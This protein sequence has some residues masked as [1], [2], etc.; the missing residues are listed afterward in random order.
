MS[1]AIDEVDVLVVG[2][3]PVGATIACLLGAYGVRTL[4][5]DKASAIFTA[6]RA[7]AL[8]NEALRVLQMAGLARDAFDTVVIPRVRMLCPYVGE[9]ARFEMSGEIDGHPKLVTFF[10]PDLERALREKASECAQVAISCGEEL[11]HFVDDGTHVLATLRRLDGSLRKV[12]AAYLIGADGASSKVRESLGLSFH[13]H[14]YAEDWLIVDVKHPPR[15]ID[16]VE[17]IC[18][19]RRP[20]PHMLAPGGRERWEFMLQP[21]ETREQMERDDT[22]RELLAPWGAV[23]EMHI[24]RKAVYRFHARTCE[25]FQRGRVFL[26][27]DA[28][29]VTPPFVG[30]GLVAGL[31]D[32]AN[33][34][35]KLA[36][37]LKGHASAAI[38]DS[39]DSER[40]PHAARM[41]ALARWMGRLI[42]PRHALAAIAV[43]GFMQQLRKVPALRRMG[44][45]QRF[46][47]KNRFDRGLFVAGKARGA[48]VRGATLPQELVRA[49]DGSA[50]W[51]DDALGPQLTCVGFGVDPE[52]QLDPSFTSTF[53]AR[54][55]AFVQ[56]GK[57][58]GGARQRA[59]AFLL[60]RDT[61]LPTSQGWV[62]VVR[63]DR[64]VLHDGPATQT[65]RVLRQSLALLAGTD[66]STASRSAS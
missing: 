65:E 44:D 25:R 51:S 50:H 6:P 33:L 2:Y 57:A 41:I 48:L 37:V 29:H 63:P 17:F 26:A 5:V 64:T 27:G 54:G 9:F 31:R 55:G 8:D 3:G 18:D 61:S 49:P 58:P 1:T 10:Q 21:G 60:E 14:S 40:R 45:E 66:I 16:H 43:H 20:T 39:Y 32:A 4:V 56:F 7:I 24:E 12:Q 62:A 38:L 23:E 35:W 19:P 28:A 30:Q 42:V 46:K 52:A 11:V 47:P 53:R 13:G 22:I 59:D 36:W 34:C 15:P